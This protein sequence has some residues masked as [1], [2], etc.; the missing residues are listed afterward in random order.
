MAKSKRINE[1]EAEE[2]Q[3]RMSF[4]E[5]LEELRKRIIRAMLGSVLAVGGC[6]YYCKEIVLIAVQPYRWAMRTAGYP[7]F[8]TAAKP[9]EVV[10]ENLTLGVQAGLI[11][12]SP[13]IIYHIWSFV[14]AGLYQKERKVVYRYVAPSAILFL[15]GVGFFYFIVLPLTLRFFVTF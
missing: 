7:A 11:L 6:V 5:H 14:A 13:W 10:M 8:L 3:S 4:G 12:S 9:T 2:S 15:L 1:E